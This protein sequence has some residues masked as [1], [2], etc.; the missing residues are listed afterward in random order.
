MSQLANSGCVWHGAAHLC[1]LQYGEG[2]WPTDAKIIQV[3][4]NQRFL[5]LTKEV[6]DYR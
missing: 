4:A 1:C 2:Y 6:I 5:G 3:D